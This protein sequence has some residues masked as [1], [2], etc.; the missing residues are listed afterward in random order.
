MNPLNL[1]KHVQNLNVVLIY[2]I[3]EVMKRAPPPQSLKSLENR[4][5]REK[6]LLSSATSAKKNE[7]P[8]L[9]AWTTKKHVAV[10][11][12]EGGTRLTR[13]KSPEVDRTAR[14]NAEKWIVNLQAWPK[15][16]KLPSGGNV[17]DQPPRPK[18]SK[19]KAINKWPTSKEESPKIGKI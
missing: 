19:N 16:L 5:P 12:Q 7:T 8:P 17:T 14:K 1:I 11:T 9:N 4:T 15:S 3:S 2:S 13:I 6:P 10:R 18:S